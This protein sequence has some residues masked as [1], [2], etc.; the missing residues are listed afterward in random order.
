MI[1]LLADKDG[2]NLHI[3]HWM[4]Y[5]AVYLDHWAL[6]DLSEDDQMSVRFVGAMKARRGTLALSWTNLAEFAIGTNVDLARKAENFINANLPHIFFLEPNPF[7][8]ID[9]ENGHLAGG[10]PTPPHADQEFLKAFVIFSGSN[11]RPSSLTLTAHDLF[12]AAQDKGLAWRKDELGDTF[13]G[14]I[15]ALRGELEND[16]SFRSELKRP[17]QGSHVQAATRDILRELM[18]AFLIDKRK[19]VT[20]ND[21]MDFFHAVVSVAYCDF[22][23]LDKYWETLVNRVRSRFRQVD[24]SVPMAT[25]FS[26]KTN[27]IE[28]CLQW[29]ESGVGP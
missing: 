1:T 24:A 19:R 21:A 8:V 26:K 20:R 9:H 17:A 16:V 4:T 22:V 10:P 2:T 23:L 3:D 28:R 15:T 29:L 12:Q 13:I 7:V 25:V 18:R 14:R 5:P 6:G 11:Q 27:G